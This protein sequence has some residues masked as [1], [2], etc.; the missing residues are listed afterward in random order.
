MVEIVKP[1]NEK[2]DEALPTKKK[3]VSIET[4]PQS[5]QCKETEDTTDE[6]QDKDVVKDSTC[7]SN[8]Q[9]T[10]HGYDED[11]SLSS[12]TSGI[13]SDSTSRSLKGLAA[14]I[15]QQ[16]GEINILEHEFM[17]Y[18]QEW[19][20]RVKLAQQ[21]HRAEQRAYLRTLYNVPEVSKNDNQ[22]F[23]IKKKKHGD[24]DRI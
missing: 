17:C 20:H 13:H 23:I 15:K 2:N 10:N 3:S 19:E 12:V 11:D 16:N 9:Y 24:R 6:H 8:C 5:T 22:E 7:Q 18:K 1:I 4:S 21:R 14:L